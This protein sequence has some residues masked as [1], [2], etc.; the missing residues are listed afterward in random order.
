METLISAYKWLTRILDAASLLPDF[1]TPLGIFCA[2]AWIATLVSAVGF[3]FSL[4]RKKYVIV[5]ENG[6]NVFPEEIEEYLGRLDAIAE[7]VVVGRT[8]EDGTLSLTAIVY[9]QLDQ[10]GKNETHEK[11]EETVR[12]QINGMNRKLVGYKQIRDV[13]FRYEPFEKTTS[14]KIKRHLI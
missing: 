8:K 10:F 1:S 2:I 13:E 7:S 11:I 14:K 4:G 12:A 9:P 3:V 6:K 5:L